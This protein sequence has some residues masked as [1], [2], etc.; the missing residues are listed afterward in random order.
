MI[1]IAIALLVFLVVSLG[2]FAVL[3][4]LDQRKSQARVLRDRLSATQKPPETVKAEVAL[5]RDEMMSRIPAFDTLLRRSER[6]TV[7]QEMLT[8]GDVDVRAGNFLLFCMASAI[9][10]G[11][12]FMVAGG[13]LMFGWAGL[14]LGF[15]I[16][17]AYASHRRAKRF[18]RFEEKFPE[19]IDTLAR[20]VRAGHAFTTALEM[21]ANE[22][23]E[24]VAGEF[25]QIFEEQKFGL[26]VRDALINLAERIPLVDVKFFVTAVML[27]RET[28]G[29]LAEILDN[30]SYVIRERF[31]ILRQV[32]VHTAQGRLTMVLL[33]ALPPTMVV[34][35]LVLNPEFIRPLFTDPLGHILIV[36]GIVL[37]TVG[38]FFIRRII[39]IQV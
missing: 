28:G 5:L 19:A 7:L 21:I 29:N 30:L 35:M 32:R 6:V 37:Q 22:I 38:Y 8:Q 4:L 39:R 33:M 10:F 25:R 31:K 11:L 26:P 15:F 14:V 12:A 20:A 1:Q 27:Q 18:Q 34:V 17:Y 9:V 2:A 24:P 13:S 36:G 23:S 3:S 16:P